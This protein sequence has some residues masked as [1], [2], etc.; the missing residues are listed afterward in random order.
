[1]TSTVA[2]H[3]AALRSVVNSAPEFMGVLYFMFFLLVCTY[4]KEQTEDYGL[5]AVNFLQQHHM[6]INSHTAMIVGSRLRLSLLINGR[7]TPAAG[8]A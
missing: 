7:H 4:T 8:S 5:L 6:Q 2:N 3:L 1:M